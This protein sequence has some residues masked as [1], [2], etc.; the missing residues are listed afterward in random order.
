[1][2]VWMGIPNSGLLFWSDGC[3]TL[4]RE[5]ECQSALLPW[6]AGRSVEMGA[7]LHLNCVFMHL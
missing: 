2:G 6:G 1:M 7:Y 3:H 4:P 5:A